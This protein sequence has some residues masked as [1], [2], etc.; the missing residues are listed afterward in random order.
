MSEKKET[1]RIAIIGAGGVGGYL[2]GMLAK[3]YDTVSLVARGAR[4]AAI[5]KNG[6]LLHSDLNG[7]ICSVPQTLVGSTRELGVQDYVFICVKNYS[8]EEVLP[9]LEEIL[10][11]DTVIIPVMNGT[12]AAERVRRAVTKGTVV[13]SVIYIVAFA[14]PDYSIAPQDPDPAEQEKIHALSDLLK[15]AGVDHR[16][17]EDIELDIWK[18]YI[19]NCAYNISTACYDCAIGEIRRDAVRAAE[20]ESLA[21]EAW[22]IGVKKGVQL[23]EE[24]LAT[25][26]DRFYHYYADQTTSSLQRDFHAGR[27]IELETFSGYIVKQAKLL[28]VEAPV[29]EK[30]YQ[31]LSEK[32]L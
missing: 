30:M 10:H 4:K 28:G 1:P 13:D 27:P 32:V 14:N 17:S 8:L 25:I 29:S 6:I 26:I 31:R 21:K 20:Y 5:E 23:K 19:L 9:E 18:K 22:Q 11:E 3:C 15:N 2:A 7:E 12:D 16:I 24:H